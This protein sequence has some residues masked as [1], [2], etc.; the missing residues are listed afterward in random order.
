MIPLR[1]LWELLREYLAAHRLKV[2]LLVALMV[3]TTVLQLLMPQVVVRF[4]DLAV[5]G[6]PPQALTQAALLYLGLAFVSQAMG[7]ARAYVTEDVGWLTTNALREK[8]ALHCLRLDMPFHLKHTPGQLIERIDG[9]VAVLSGFFS[10]LLISALASLLMLCGALAVLVTVDMRIAAA[11]AAL[12]IVGAL[13][14][15][16]M[17]NVGVPFNTADRETA[18]RMTGYIQERLAGTEDVRARGATPYVLRGLWVVMR[19]R[20]HARSKAAGVGMLQW[21]TMILLF[22]ASTALTFSLGGSLYLAGAISIG[23]VFLVLNYGW[24]ITAPMTNLTR[25]LEQLQ[26]A[27][28]S[29]KRVRELL[30]ETPAARVAD[31]D[32]VRLPATGALAVEL[33]GVTF[34]YPGLEPVLRDVSF[35]LEP[36]K[37]LGL[38]GRTGAGKS[39]ITR[40]LLRLYDP[41]SGHVRLNGTRLTEVTPREVRE[42]V[43]MVTQEVQLFAASVRDNLTFFNAALPDA[44]VVEALETL[45]LGEWLRA[46]PRGL[47]TPLASDGG[48][49]SAGEAQLLAFARVFLRDPGLVILDEASSR[50]DPATERRI[51]RAVGVLLDGRTGVLVAHRLATVRRADDILVLE[52]GREVEHGERVALAADAAS[53]FAGLLRTGL[54]VALA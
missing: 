38:L 2:T 17:R 41:V 21:G 49:L 42:R 40:L 11:F 8:V 14:L 51:E 30:A 32:A 23:T 9:D 48:G 29:I 16:R 4:I 47:D 3:L 34:A 37:V 28:A 52:D 33:D 18:T 31:G 12:A 50:L 25:Q 36:G 1:H 44:R 26:Q 43:G 6:A 15:H 10:Q 22:G 54:E 5:A 20:M 19:E 24:R 7:V 35:R 39:T 13:V 45:G 27:S 46:L 53:R